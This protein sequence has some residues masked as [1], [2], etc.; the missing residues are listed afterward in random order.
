MIEALA[1]VNPYGDRAAPDG[2]TFRMERGEIVE[3]RGPNGADL[4]AEASPEPPRE[5]GS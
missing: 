2:V 3:F 4:A 5:G 1:L